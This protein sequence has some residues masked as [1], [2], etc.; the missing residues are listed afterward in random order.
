[1]LRLL[2]T[3]MK[4]RTFAILFVATLSACPAYAGAIDS[5]AIIA[6]HNSLR[7]EVGETEKLSYSPALAATAQTWA[8]KL[9][10]SNH[11]HM[12]HSI[13]N[14]QYGENL[15]WG[16]ALS[17]SDGR[18]EL[19]KVSAEQVVNNWGSEKADYD[20]TSNQCASGKM[21]GHY[22]QIV[23]QTTTAVGCGMA[24]CEDTKEQIWACQY[25]PAG[26]WVGRKPY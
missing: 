3:N 18:K 14:G 10:R 6:A 1:M 25:R 20:Y 16:S 2:E 15:F 4:L 9:K 17:W 11:C 7:T 19:Q 8:D 22:T 12:R 21:C 26:N 24:V 23:W 13:P 5:A